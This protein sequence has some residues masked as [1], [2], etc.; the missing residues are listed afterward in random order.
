MYSIAI[1]RKQHLPETT[2]QRTNE[3]TFEEIGNV[4]LRCIPWQT[5]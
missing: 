1:R 5:A 4:F 3:V 2:S